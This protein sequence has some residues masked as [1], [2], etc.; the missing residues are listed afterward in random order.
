[1][2]FRSISLSVSNVSAHHVLLRPHPKFCS[3]TQTDTFNPSPI[4]VQE[5]PDIP[6]ICPVKLLKNYVDLTKKLCDEKGI[7]RPDHLWLSTHLKPIT[8][9]V[10]RRWVREII[11]WGDPNPT[12]LGSH[13]HSIRGHVST[14]LLASRA[15]VKEIFAAMNWKSR[16]TFF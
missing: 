5:F 10:I 4:V 16:S 3:K 9:D 12:R 14:S 15:S 6:Q 11:F 2:E 13:V 1:M 7:V 8:Q